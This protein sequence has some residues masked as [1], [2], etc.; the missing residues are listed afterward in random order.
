MAEVA[1]SERKDYFK[2]ARTLA[3]R[4]LRR[5]QTPVELRAGGRSHW[6]FDGREAISESTVLSDVAHRI[7]SRAWNIGIPY[8]VVAGLGVEGRALSIGVASESAEGTKWVI[9]NDDEADRD[10]SNGFGLHGAP[11][12]N[13]RV[14]VVDGTATTGDS[15]GTLVGMVRAE[16]GIV[17]DAMVIVDRSHGR[18]AEAMGTLGVKL[19]S[20]FE[21]DEAGGLLRPVIK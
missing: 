5:L 15:L 3:A 4:G 10:L 11:V 14:L 19:I 18:A 6:Y 12:S 9:A 2:L 8:R 17:T 1:T 20:L 13:E 21:F 7:V 16:E